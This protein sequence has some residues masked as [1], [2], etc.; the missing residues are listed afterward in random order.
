MQEIMLKSGNYL[1]RNTHIYFFY[2]LEYIKTGKY[3]KTR[4]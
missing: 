3:F 2:H 1:I 4:L